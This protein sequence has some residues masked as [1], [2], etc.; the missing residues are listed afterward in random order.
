[1]LYPENDNRDP[2][3]KREGRRPSPRE[4]ATGSGA[5]GNSLLKRNFSRLGLLYCRFLLERKPI[6]FPGQSLHVPRPLDPVAQSLAEARDGQIQAVIPIDESAI[7]PDRLP[8]FLAA[9]QFAWPLK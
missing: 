6:S 2:S 3:R 9:N 4:P 5:P 8:Q 7:L 1:M